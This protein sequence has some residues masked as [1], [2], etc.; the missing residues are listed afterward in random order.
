[1]YFLPFYMICML[2]KS[3]LVCEVC[4]VHCRH[5]R[6]SVFARAYCT[7]AFKHV[8]A[9]PAGRLS[10]TLLILSLYCLN[11]TPCFLWI[12]FSSAPFMQLLFSVKLRTATA[13]FQGKTQ[14]REEE[15]DGELMSHGSFGGEYRK[16]LCHQDTTLIRDSLSLSPMSQWLQTV[17]AWWPHRLRPSGQLGLAPS[18]TSLISFYELIINWMLFDAISYRLW[19]IF[20]S[21]V[22]VCIQTTR[23]AVYLI[24]IY[25]NSIFR[26]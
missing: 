11:P 7:S 16:C 1:M 6:P 15:E 19:N 10:S 26:D 3:F 21:C 2:F 22:Q 24:D 5:I 23:F 14:R 8:R 17:W 9:L 13:H 20:E 18:V 4:L 12:T 25:Y